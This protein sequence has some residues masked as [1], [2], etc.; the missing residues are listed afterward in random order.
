M[1]DHIKKLTKR[2]AVTIMDRQL[3]NGHGSCVLWFTGLSGA[4]KSTIAAQLELHLLNRKV[5]C[6]VLDGEML[7]EGLNQD[8]GYTAAD[9][10]ENIRRIGEVAKLFVDA[11][12]I[13]VVATVSPNKVNREMAR[14]IFGS[15]QY[16]EVFVDCPLEVCEQRDPKGFYWRSKLGLMGST[17]YERPEQPELTLHT[18][19]QTVNESV[20]Q[21]IQYMEQHELI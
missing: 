18:N 3:L 17:I 6:Y 9:R 8:L 21:L 5:K 4:G 19:E 7:Q 11:G 12:F 10:S 20:A 14:S 16:H 1:Q 2:A 15:K 13:V